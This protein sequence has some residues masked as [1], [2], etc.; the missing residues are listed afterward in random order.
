MVSVFTHNLQIGQMETECYELLR[1]YDHWL[2]L[3][4]VLKIKPALKYITCYF[5][6]LHQLYVSFDKMSLHI[7]FV[8]Y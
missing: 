1:Q 8:R 3:K 4:F 5:L 7:L 2:W 6:T